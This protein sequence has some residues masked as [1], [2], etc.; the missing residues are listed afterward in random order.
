MGKEPEKTWSRDGFAEDR[1]KWRKK[2]YS[3]CVATGVMNMFFGI[4]KVFTQFKMVREGLREVV[5]FVLDRLAPSKN[6]FTI[7]EE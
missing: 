5:D 1:Q 2:P 4:G 7:E 6:D 3:F